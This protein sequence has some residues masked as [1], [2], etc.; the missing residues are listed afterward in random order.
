H[1]VEHGERFEARLP[2][3]A[4]RIDDQQA[5]ARGDAD[6]VFGVFVPPA[7]YGGCV[8]C[9]L[10]L[11]WEVFR[12]DPR[13]WHDREDAE[14]LCRQFERGLSFH[15]A[16]PP[17]VGFLGLGYSYNTTSRARARDLW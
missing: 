9:G 14:A 16:P 2:V 1:H 17:F 6:I 4:V 11:T 3:L 13:A 10:V 5:M 7:F 8:R 15:Y 12:G